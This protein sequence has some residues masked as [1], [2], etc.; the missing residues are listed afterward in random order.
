MATSLLLSRQGDWYLARVDAQQARC[1]RLTSQD[2][3]R[4]LSEARALSPLIQWNFSPPGTIREGE[5]YQV[6][7]SGVTVLELTILPDISGERARAS[8]KSLRVS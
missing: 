3:R 1:H 7:L 6:E 2:M 4:L 8:L 5:E